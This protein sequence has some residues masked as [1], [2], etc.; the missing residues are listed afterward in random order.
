MF[1]SSTMTVSPDI[2]EAHSLRGWFDSAGR[3]ASLKSHSNVG[4]AAGG[5]GAGGFKADSY[6]TIGEIKDE[7]IGM[8]DTTDWFTVKGTAIF[9]KSENMSYPACST[10][11]C[12]KKVVEDGGQWRCEKCQKNWDQPNWR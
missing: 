1:S 9:I 2:P 8:N 7:N 12:N 4:G 3:S 5:S 11:G 6:K 10:D